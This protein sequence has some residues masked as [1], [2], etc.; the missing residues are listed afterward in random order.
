MYSGLQ[1]SGDCSSANV[2]REQMQATVG[3]NQR[4][5]SARHCVTNGRGIKQNR[6]KSSIKYCGYPNA[7]DICHGSIKEAEPRTRTYRHMYL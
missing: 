5:A 4:Q 1:I 3:D 2:N 7:M 6:R